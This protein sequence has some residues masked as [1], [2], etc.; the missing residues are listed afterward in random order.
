MTWLCG[1]YRIEEGYPVFV[2]LTKEP[3][4]ELSKI[5]DWMSV[6]LPNERIDVWID[7]T[8]NPDE[9][10]PYALSDMVIEKS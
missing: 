3:T 9:I 1:L 5:H 8:Y 7:L 4:A 10:I 6:M 2:I